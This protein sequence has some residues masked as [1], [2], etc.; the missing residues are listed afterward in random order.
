[1]SAMGI[2]LV[3]YIS[4]FF[5]L[6]VAMYFMVQKSGK[7]YIIAGKSLPF[8]LV[9]TMLLRNPWMPTPPWVMPPGYMEADGGPDFSS[10]LAW[11]CA[12]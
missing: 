7:R 11:R 5:V 1:M 4:I 12:L 8:F 3:I 6:G 9:G 10:P 2:G